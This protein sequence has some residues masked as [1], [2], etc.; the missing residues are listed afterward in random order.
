MEWRLLSAEP[1]LSHI[2]EQSFVD[3]HVHKNG[4]RLSLRGN[5][6]RGY[7]RIIIVMAQI[8][9]NIMK[10]HFEKE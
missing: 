6:P 10:Y 9:V 1:P 8:K 2:P 5:K 7:F 4:K 3:L